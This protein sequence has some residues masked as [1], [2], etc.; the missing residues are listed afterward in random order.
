HY[1]EQADLFG[2]RIGSLMR[3]REKLERDGKAAKLSAQNW[4]KVGMLYVNDK[5]PKLGTLEILLE[6]LEED[7]AKVARISEALTKF[8]E[9]EELDVPEG[10]KLTVGFR[11]GVPLR[12]VI[13]GRETLPQSAEK[14]Q[15]PAV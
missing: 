3:A 6:V 13:G 10:T 7:K 4:K 2:E 12:I 1:E 8:E 5:D 14:R 11:S 9:V 15:V